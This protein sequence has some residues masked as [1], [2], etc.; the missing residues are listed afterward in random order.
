MA[1]PGP[2]RTPDIPSWDLHARDTPDVCGIL[3]KMDLMGMNLP[4]W[5]QHPG[6]S[7]TGKILHLKTG[8]PLKDL[9]KNPQVQPLTKY[10][11]TP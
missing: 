1:S 9:G 7:N 6:F 8:T 2:H 11:H 4:S 5:K 10:H 3:I